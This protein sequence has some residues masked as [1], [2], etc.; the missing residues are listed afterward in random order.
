MVIDF[1]KDG[2]QCKEWKDKETNGKTKHRLYVLGP[3]GEIGHY[4][5][6]E[7]LFNNSAKTSE[8]F[9]FVETNQ[10]IIS[11]NNEGQKVYLGI[12]DRNSNKINFEKNLDIKEISDKI[13]KQLGVN[14][15]IE[16]NIGPTIEFKIGGKSNWAK[17]NISISVE[18]PED[19]YEL[20]SN[21]SDLAHS[22]L[23]EEIK[24]LKNR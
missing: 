6:I 12:N 9:E 24:R 22:I 16:I 2:Y 4:D 13:K 18:N 21:A 5:F 11:I 23:D 15:R 20:Y 7:G 8:N 19:I 10:A 14:D 3:Q 17:S 1:I